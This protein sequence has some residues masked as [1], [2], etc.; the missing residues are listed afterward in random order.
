MRL[1]TH[2]RYTMLGIFNG[3]LEIFKAG[4]TSRHGDFFPILFSSL[5]FF[6]SSGGTG[7]VG[8]EI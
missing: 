3:V 2:T 1:F 5:S 8:S 7:A 6:Y 4:R